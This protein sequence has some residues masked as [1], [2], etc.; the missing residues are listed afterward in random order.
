[1]S[2]LPNLV[3]TGVGKGGTTSLFWYLSQH[4]DVCASDEKEIRYFAALTEGGSELPPIEEYTKHFRHCRG[5]RYAL[6]ASPQYFHGGRR[7]VD[8][9]HEVLG[10]PRVVVSLRD[11]VDR[12]WSQFRFVKTR[13]GPVPESLTFDDYVRRSE[14]VWRERRP[15][16]PE[17]VPYWHLAGGHYADH[18]DPWFEGF[19]ED[20]RVVFFEHIASDPR[21]V[22]ADLADWLG[23]DR[24]PVASFAYSV[25]NRTV[26]IR[27]QLLQR[28]ALFLNREDILGQR[29]R[30]KAPLRA[31]YYAVNRRSGGETMSPETREHLRALFAPANARLAAALRERGYADLPAWLSSPP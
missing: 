10:H 31:I 2:R 11:P 26:P 8:A 5:E 1:L 23:I 19:G 18:V 4:P 3:I 29:R 6:E 21:K 30:L 7:V 16:T 27:S 13:F 20:F 17:T 22:V 14:Q 25:E 15:L 24:G 12:L 9:M 28:A